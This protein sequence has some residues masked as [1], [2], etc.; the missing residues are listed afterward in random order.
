MNGQELQIEQNKA[1]KSM[2]ES[3]KN[4]H[5]K[6]LEMAEHIRQYD[7]ALGQKILQLRSEGIQASIVKEVAKSDPQ[8][9]DIKFN[10]SVCEAESRAAKENINIKKKIFD[11]LEA[12]K[13]RELG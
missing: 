5:E 2:E 13:K 6:D 4:A 9:A 7:I 3:N 11:S 1:Y 8:I 10:A 12:T